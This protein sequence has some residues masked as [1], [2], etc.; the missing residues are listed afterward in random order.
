LEERV[1]SLDVAKW[2]PR[3]TPVSDILTINIFVNWLKFIKLKALPIK[4][5][6]GSA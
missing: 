6:G 4:V 1:L 3:K 2:N 5:E